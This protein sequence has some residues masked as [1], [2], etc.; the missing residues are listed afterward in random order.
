MRIIPF[1]VLC[2]LIA[3]GVFFLAAN[4]VDNRFV[5]GMVGVYEQQIGYAFYLHLL[6]TLAWLLAF[7]CAM[8]TT[9]KFFTGR[10]QT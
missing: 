1:L 7:L 8:I 4:R 2:S 6:G 3:N 9:Y 5:Q 10:G